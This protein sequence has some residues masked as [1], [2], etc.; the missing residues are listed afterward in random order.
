MQTS[1]AV[2]D[3]REGNVPHNVVV[4]GGGVAGPSAP[5]EFSTFR[6]PDKCFGKSLVGRRIER[7]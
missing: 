5:K 1:R 2:S 7:K 3:K 4:V 6:R